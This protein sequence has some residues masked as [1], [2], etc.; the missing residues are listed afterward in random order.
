MAH[1]PHDVRGFTLI[2]LM[3]V[4]AIIGLLAS[5]AMPELQR[6]TIRS[7]TAERRVVVMTIRRA[8]TDWVMTNDGLPKGK[9]ELV[10]PADPVGTAGSVKRVP[11]FSVPDWNYVIGASGQREI[12]G[13][14][15]YSYT[16]WLRPA[17]G[18][19]GS[20][21][22]TVTAIGDLDGDSNPSVRMATWHLANGTSTSDPILDQVP[23]RW[24]DQEVDDGTF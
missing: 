1:R 19:T 10:G 18:T 12:E 14:L 3:V 9:T 20:F 15:Y 8:I 16:F 5:I 22:L 7:K 4:V 2:E 13:A 23:S 11:D 21:D 17:A 24:L 6:M